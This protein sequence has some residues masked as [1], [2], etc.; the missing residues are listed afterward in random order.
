[1]VRV[2]SAARVLDTRGTFERAGSIARNTREE[3]ERTF[4]KPGR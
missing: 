1:M 2:R 3:Q 4:V